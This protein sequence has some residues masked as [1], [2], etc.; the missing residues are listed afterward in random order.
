[1]ELKD[2]VQP[3]WVMATKRG[4]GMLLTFAGTVVPL[5]NLYGAQ[6]NI[7]VEPPMVSLLGEAVGNVISSVGVAAGVVLWVW[8]SFR[9]TAPVTVAPPK[10]E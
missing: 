4:W 10:A 9:P 6:Y 7:H 8:G 5:I 3:K 2:I 1:M